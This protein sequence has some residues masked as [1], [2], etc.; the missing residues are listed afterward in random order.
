MKVC[1]SVTNEW[2]LFIRMYICRSQSTCSLIALLST[3]CVF[4]CQ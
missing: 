1:T 2:S 3:L 4:W